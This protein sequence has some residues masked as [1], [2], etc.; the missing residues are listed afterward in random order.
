II[1]YR[2]CVSQLA[3]NASGVEGTQFTSKNKLY[4]TITSFSVQHPF[5]KLRIFYISNNKFS[6]MQT[7]FINVDKKKII[8]VDIFD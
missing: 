3:R 5:P 6:T 7:E 2:G 4:G 8:E 1:K